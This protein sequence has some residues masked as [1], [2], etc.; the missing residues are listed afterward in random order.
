MNK[1]KWI[2]MG[3]MMAAIPLLIAF[4][5]LPE[6]Y[7]SSKPDCNNTPGYPL[8][9]TGDL[10]STDYQREVVQRLE[11]GK[12]QDFRYFFKTFVS[13]AGNDYVIVNFR[14]GEQ[15]FDVKMKVNKWGKLAGMRRTNGRSYPEELYELAW[16]IAETSGKKEVIYQD[17]H[18]VID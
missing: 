13:E 7:F 3:C 4:I 6:A 11:S 10:A 18:A 8:A 14:N 5:T 1:L 15:C 2:L 9:G 12:P 17:M 16:T